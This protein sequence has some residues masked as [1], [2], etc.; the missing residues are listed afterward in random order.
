MQ[1]LLSSFQIDF[2]RTLQNL[3]RVQIVKRHSWLFRYWPTFL[4]FLH[5]PYLSPLYFRSSLTFR[6]LGRGMQLLLSSFQIDFQRT[7][8]NL[9]RV[10]IVKRHSWLFR[11]WPTFL[12][13]LH[14]PYL[15]PLY[16]RSSLTFRMLGRGM[17][18]LLSSFQIDFQ[19]TL[20]N[21]A[22]VQIV[23]RHSWLFRYWPTFL[24]FLHEPYLSPLYFRSSL[25]FRM[26]GRGMQLLLSSFQ[27]D[28][29]RTLQNLARVQIVKRHSWLFRYWPT[30][31]DFLHEPYLSPLYFRSS[32]TFRMLGRGMQLLLSSFQIDFQRTLQ[33]LARVQIVKRHSWLFRYWPTFLDFLHEPYLSPLYFRSSLTFRMLGRGMQLLLSSFQI[34][35]QR[36][37]QNLARVQIV[38][39]HSWLFRYWPTF[40]DF[41]HEPYL[42][43]LYFRSSLTFRMLGR[44]MQLL[45][46]SFQIDFQ[47]TL[48]NLARVQIVKRHSWLFRYW[49][50]FLDFLHEPYLSPLY[51]RSSLT[52][53]MLGRGMQLL[54]SSFQIDFQRTLQNLARVQI[55]KR[56]SWLFRYW[57]TFLDFLHEPYLSP[58]Y[59]RSSLTFRMLGRGMQLLLS[60]F[61]IDFQRTLQNL[62]RVQIVKRHSWL[63]RY[64]PTFLDFL[65]EPYLSPLYFRSSLTFRMLGRGMQLLLSSFQIDFQR[66][67][68]NLARVQIVKRHS[69]LFRYWQTFLDFLHEPYLSPLHFRSSLTFRMLGR[70][71]Q[72]LLSSFQIDFQRTLQNLA[73]V[74]IVK[75]HSWLF[76]YW[77]TFLDFLHEPYLSPLHFRSSLTF[78]ML[79]RGMQ[80]LLSSFHIYFQRTF[81]NL[82][83]VLPT[84]RSSD[85][86]RYWQ[87]F[88]D[89]L[90][91]PYLSPLYFRSLL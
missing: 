48:Q 7:L 51:F 68:Q 30:F 76:R 89:F 70:G 47:R 13:F 65:H 20:Q 57:P 82:A 24:D 43:P 11:Y 73:R 52:F 8:Q 86:F 31:L 62:A 18:L 12:D 33:N 80:L 21:L 25:T 29:Q 34:D 72:L 46:S 85:L 28:F 39:R 77:Q 4:D 44:G 42:S 22:R 36:T 84:R 69:W 37:L 66:T 40:L 78:L 41:L 60:S 75:R 59:F 9:A 1:L 64:W 49:P 61:Q 23:K 35:F 53:R 55:V 5:E 83:H 79:G 19:R 71:M 14:E 27:I 2:Q 3:A 88:L 91:E 63:F 38:K 15:S 16:F 32:L 10:Q 87:T 26:L 56:H 54:L 6:M 67:L 81:H 58:L 17:Q 90:H 74:Q 50:T 45:L